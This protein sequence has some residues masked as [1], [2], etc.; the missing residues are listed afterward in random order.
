MLTRTERYLA[1]SPEHNRTH[2]R[3]WTAGSDAGLV[4]SLACA[5]QERYLAL[6][7]ELLRV[8]ATFEKVWIFVEPRI[9]TS[10]YGGAG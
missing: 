7:T 1:G 10:V 2:R 3:V 6:A 9:A 8:V 5:V 4:V